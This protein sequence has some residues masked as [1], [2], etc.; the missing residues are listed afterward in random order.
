MARSID[1]R[2]LSAL[3][4]VCLPACGWLP[5]PG[6]AV[7][8][9]TAAAPEAPAPPPRLT[10]P[11]APT[12]EVGDAVPADVRADRLL[13]RRLSRSGGGWMNG[14][15]LLT[16][17]RVH[18][19][20]GPSE[21]MRWRDL[22]TL[23][24][25][26]RLALDGLRDHGQLRDAQGR[27]GWTEQSSE[28]D[29][30]VRWMVKRTDDMRLDISLWGWPAPALRPL[31]EIDATLRALDDTPPHQAAFALDGGAWV[32]LPCRAGQ[33]RSVRDLVLAMEQA[34]AGG[35]PTGD[36][37]LTLYR[38]DPAGSLSW[39]LHEEGGVV[40]RNREGERT[41]HRLA[42]A[43]RRLT[44]AVLETLVLDT[45]PGLCP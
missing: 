33:V 9:P 14:I 10:A 28:A 26:D 39:T 23:S 41:T 30:V 42:P 15:R 16:D 8:P 7:D 11:A 19:G 20:E 37:V 40:H 31:H 25:A 45:L 13:V 29:P 4:A 32:G 17:G 43:T 6:P 21:A 38:M 5:E 3:L 27:R 1:R 2:V 44:S 18:A 36:P 12:T 35:P 22:G 34:P 24:P